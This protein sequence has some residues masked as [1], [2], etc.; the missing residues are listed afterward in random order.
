MQSILRKAGTPAGPVGVLAL[1]LGLSYYLVQGDFSLIVEG[2]LALG[3]LLLLFFVGV[4]RDRVLN[5]LGSRQARRGTNAVVMMLAFLGIIVLV[6]VLGARHSTRWDLTESQ[7]FTLSSQTL[8]VLTAIQQP[9]HVVGF[10]Q[11]GD[12]RRQDAQDLLTEYASRS[13]KLTYEFVDPDLKPTL[14]Q[15]YGIRDYQMVFT[16]GERRQDVMTAGES[17]F[18]SALLKLTGGEQKSVAFV[19]GHGERSLDGTDNASYQ[20]AKAALEADNYAVTILSLATGPVAE[21][22]EALIIAGSKQAWLDQERQALRD[23]LRQG[24]KVLLLY[25]PGDDAQLDDIAAEYGVA[26]GQ[27]LIVDRVSSLFPD[28]GTP[29]ISR[30]ESSPITKGLPQTVFPGVA[31]LMPPEQPPADVTVNPLAYTSE[32]SWTEKDVRNPR[33]DEGVDSR[34]PLAIAVSVEVGAQTAGEAQSGDDAKRTRLVIV[35][36]ADFASNAYLDL[37]GNRDLL[38]NAVNWLAESEELITIRPKPVVD[39]T[40]FLTATQ[41]NVVWY[42]TVL[43]LPLLVLATGVSVWWSRR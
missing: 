3:V 27:D 36:D 26:L 21:G 24:G 23:Y 6:N 5:A 35:G 19:T 9:V 28:I 8:S 10:Y 38:V 4:E 14:A 34:G 30:Y 25:D 20:R 18:T 31:A 41:A 40:L 43:I 39:R 22:T 42:S 11:D 1:F 16:S 29:I 2:L 37:V 7:A 12:P 17:E 15:S 33:Y 32:Q 13:D